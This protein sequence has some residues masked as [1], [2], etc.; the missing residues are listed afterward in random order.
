VH[1]KIINEIG[2]DSLIL[3][4]ITMAYGVNYI[5]SEKRF[6][7]GNINMITSIRRSVKWV[8]IITILSIV[9]GLINAFW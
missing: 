6:P 3:S 2:F 7:N 9:G 1:D 4:A 5:T 8:I